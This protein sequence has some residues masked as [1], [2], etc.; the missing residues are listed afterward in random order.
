MSCLPSYPIALAMSLILCYRT[1]QL[2][3]QIFSKLT[4]YVPV[5]MSCYRLPKQQRFQWRQLRPQLWRRKPE[6]NATLAFG[7]EWEMEESQHPGW[8]QYAPLIQY[9]LPQVSSCQFATQNYHSLSLLPQHGA[10]SMR[11]KHEQSTRHCTTPF[12]CSFQYRTVDYGQPFLYG[13]ITR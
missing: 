5:T 12:I 13:C 6:V 1:C 2:L 9:C 3:C 11:A 4:I 10:V 8:K 7:T